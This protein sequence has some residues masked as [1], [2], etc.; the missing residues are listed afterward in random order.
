MRTLTLCSQ[1]VRLELPCMMRAI[2]NMAARYHSFFKYVFRSVA[3]DARA[4]FVP[5][6]SA[7]EIALRIVA[8]LRLFCL[9]VNCF[10]LFLTPLP[11][12]GPR[13]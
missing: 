13:G 6:T 1:Q 8:A 2:D 11:S 4:R 3:A 10:F 9:K 7:W 12:S 5:F